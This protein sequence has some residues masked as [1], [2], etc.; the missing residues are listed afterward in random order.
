MTADEEPDH[1]P[2]QAELD[3]E[4]MAAIA[5][6]SKDKDE[7]VLYPSRPVDPGPPPRVLTVPARVAFW[8]AAVAGLIA[9]VY[10]FVNVGTIRGLLRDRLRDGLA[11]DPRNAAP[12]DRIDTMANFFPPFMLIMIVVFLAIEYVLLVGAATHHSRNCR[13]FYLAA[14]LVNLLCIPIGIDLLFRYPDVWSAL[15]VIGWIQFALLAVSALCTIQR[16]VN[17]WL[18][19]STRMRPMRMV[20]G[21]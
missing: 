1:V 5:R 4:D 6:R 2:S 10:G 15:P 16:S 20:K 19:Q 13:N 18:P 3:A 8:G 12:A 17:R 21:R 9:F 11:S 7:A 14:V